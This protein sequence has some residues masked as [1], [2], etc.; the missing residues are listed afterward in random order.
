MTNRIQHIIDEIRS[1]KNALSDLLKLEKEKVAK[2]EVKLR[3]LEELLKLFSKDGK[4][5]FETYIKTN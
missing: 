2:S 3:E 1:K 4:Q 5:L